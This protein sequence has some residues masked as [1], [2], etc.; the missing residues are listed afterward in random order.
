MKICRGC[1]KEYADT[2]ENFYR[3]NKHAKSKNGLVGK[4]KECYEKEE[5]DSAREEGFVN[6]EHKRR[7]MSK[8]SKF[9]FKLDKEWTEELQNEFDKY[10]GGGV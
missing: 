5:G 7:V 4:C 3:N 9:S 1:K 2:E 8:R 10:L 6:Y